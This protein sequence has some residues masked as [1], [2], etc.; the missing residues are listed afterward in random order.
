MVIENRQIGGDRSLRLFG[1]TA[2]FTLFLVGLALSVVFPY[3]I[4]FA[5]FVGAIALAGAVCGVGAICYGLLKDI[6]GRT[7][8]FGYAPNMSYMAGKK[9]KKKRA[10]AS[11]DEQKT[12]K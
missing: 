11:T 2:L 7:A 10:E 1:R 8:T 6:L 12:E 9:T 5:A 4:G 3:G